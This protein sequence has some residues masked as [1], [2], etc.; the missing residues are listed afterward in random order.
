MGFWRTNCIHFTFHFFLINY[1][2]KST[3]PDYFGFG[4]ALTIAAGGIVGYLKAGSTASLGMGLLMSGLSGV[5]AHQMSQNPNNYYLLL[6]S[7]SLLTVIMGS[8]FY[9]SGKFMPAGLVATL[10]ILMAGRIITNALMS[11]KES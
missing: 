6:G 11:P 2:E 9:N 7:S 10:S 5:G 1:F 3:M 4:Y 8:R